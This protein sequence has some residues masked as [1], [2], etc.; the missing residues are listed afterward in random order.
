[1]IP[2][3]PRPLGW[4]VLLLAGLSG[5]WWRPIGNL[6]GMLA[7]VLAVGMLLHLVAP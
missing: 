5:A 7:A 6:L 2:Y 1:M 3:L 4:L